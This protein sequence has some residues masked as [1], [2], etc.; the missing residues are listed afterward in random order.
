MSTYSKTLDRAPHPPLPAR[1]SG[2]HIIGLRL[3]TALTK[4]VDER[5]IQKRHVKGRVEGVT[6]E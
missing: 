6:E 1:T 3:P 5:V 4:F 2:Q